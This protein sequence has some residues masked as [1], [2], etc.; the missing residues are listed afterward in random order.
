M[1]RTR[2][3]GVRCRCSLLLNQVGHLSLVKSGCDAADFIF[4][5]PLLDCREMSD[6]DR[7]EVPWSLLS[8]KLLPL[9]SGSL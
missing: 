6:G 7:Q 4:D 5:V 3:L 8:K 1:R 9:R 2:R